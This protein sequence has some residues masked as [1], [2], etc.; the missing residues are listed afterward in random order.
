MKPHSILERK[1]VYTY[2]AEDILKYDGMC[3]CLSIL[4]NAVRN[5]SMSLEE[6]YVEFMLF[7]PDHNEAFWWDKGDDESRVFALLLSA[8]MCNQ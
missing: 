4:M 7:K 3:C 6:E 1:K 8:E 5:S 2:A